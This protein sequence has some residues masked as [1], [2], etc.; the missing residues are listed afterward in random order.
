M[1]LSQSIFILGTGRS[2]TTIVYRML[3]SHPDLGWYSNYIDRFPRVPQLAL[4]SRLLDVTGHGGRRKGWRRALP[5]P[6]E[7][8]GVPRTLT[9]GLFVEK[10]LLADSSLDPAVL[11]RYRRH[12]AAVLR[13]QGKSRF[14]HKHTGFAR[15]GFLRGVDPTGQFF[16]VLR[17]GRAV[18]NSLLNV[19]WW[20]GSL[21]SWWW[22]PMPEGY[23]EQFE[24]ANRDPLVLAALVWLR[25]TELIEQELQ[26]L[27]PA[28]LMTLRYD[29]FV[30]AP[31]ESLGKI[32]TFAG[33]DE[34]AEFLSRA[35]R[36][37]VRDADQ[38]W[39]RNLSTSQIDVLN[40]LLGERLEAYG[41]ES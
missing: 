11:A 31:V 3:A 4:L 15:I 23:V 1:E 12:A 36:F 13:W 19:E 20:N 39:Q 6:K 38:G 41:F 34:T 22:G 35:R 18:V 17:D 40:R 28:Q 2:G 7:A 14:L 16:H 27:P 29:R 32:C 8:L 10:N 5:V 25:L 26:A 9:G 37:N 24:R 33:L 21:D 30:R